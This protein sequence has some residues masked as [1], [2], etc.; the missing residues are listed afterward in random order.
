MT[1][2]VIRVTDDTTWDELASALA[3]VC[4]RAK[5]VPRVVG[6]EK[7]P[8]EWDTRHEQ[9]DALLTDMERARG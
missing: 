2:P 5:R 4:A 8:T 1:A 3:N 6:S 9:I 7:L